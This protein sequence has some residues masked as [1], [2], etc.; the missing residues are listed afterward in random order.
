VTFVP[1]LT[2]FAGKSSVLLL[3]LLLDSLLWSFFS[4]QIM[5]VMWAVV[6]YW[7]QWVD[8][9]LPKLTGIWHQFY[10]DLIKMGLWL[11]LLMGLI[12]YYLIS[13][14]VID[15]VVYSYLFLI[16]FVFVGPL[17]YLI[18]SRKIRHRIDVEIQKVDEQL[19][20]YLEWPCFEA[21][22]FVLQLP[23]FQYLWLIR[24][25][26]LGFRP[27]VP[28]KLAIYYLIFCGLILGFPFLSGS[29]P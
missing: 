3:F 26:W 15:T 18:L 24:N 4:A 22:Q 13:Y 19:V 29:A 23:R 20:N 17:P 27:Q 21:Q 16:P 10:A 25:Y 11:V 8:F 2:K 12:Y 9:D 28:F 5:E 14:F 7:S 1:H 6:R